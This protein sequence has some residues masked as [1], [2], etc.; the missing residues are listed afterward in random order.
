MA[1]VQGEVSTEERG[2]GVREVVEVISSRVPRT[3]IR[4]LGCILSRVRKTL[5]TFEQS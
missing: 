2:D 5:E 4:T 1:R 3:T